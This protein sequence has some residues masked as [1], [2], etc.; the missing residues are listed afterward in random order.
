MNKY[1]ASCIMYFPKSIEIISVYFF[2]FY[3]IIIKQG[4]PI[5]AQWKQI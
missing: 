2:S 3:K 4:V 1:L 5:V